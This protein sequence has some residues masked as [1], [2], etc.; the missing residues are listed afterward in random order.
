M[1]KNFNEKRSD[2]RANAWLPDVNFHKRA[3]AILIY[4][5]L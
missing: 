5:R 4:L 2:I 1:S 3:G